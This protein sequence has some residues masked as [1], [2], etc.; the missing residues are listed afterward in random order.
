MFVDNDKVMELP[1]N[2]NVSKTIKFP[3]NGNY[4]LEVNDA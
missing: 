2:L 3:L 1:A 4:I